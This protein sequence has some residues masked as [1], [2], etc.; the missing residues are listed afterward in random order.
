MLDMNLL[1]FYPRDPVMRR[2]R[3][4]LH[5]RC[6]TAITF[7]HAMIGAILD[8]LPCACSAVRV[9]KSSAHPLD[10]RRR[11]DG[12]SEEVQRS[13]RRRRRVCDRQNCTWHRFASTT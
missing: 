1:L 2:P 9:S 3:F 13:R 7:L 5:T 11:H 10:G 8:S 6:E 12:D 4:L